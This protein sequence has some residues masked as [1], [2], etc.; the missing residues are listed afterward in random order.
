MKNINKKLL[1]VYIISSICYFA[2]GFESLP[3]LSLFF[4]LKEHLHFSPEK[5]M[6]L[7]S[8]ITIPWI[9]KPV[10]GFFIDNWLSHKKWIIL[11]SLL[12]ICTCLFFG[13]SPILTIPLIILLGISGN[14]GTAFRDIS[15]DA[16]M[17][18]QGKET[19]DCGN[20]QALQWTSITIASIIVGLVG[21]WIADHSTY[22][23]AFLCLAP[24]YL[25]IILIVSQYKE[26][27]PQIF[28]N[29][30]V[31]FHKPFFTKL[32]SYKEVFTNKRFLWAC[33][34]IFLYNYSP[35]FG[36][37]LMFIERDKFLWTGT[38]MGFLG[39]ITSAVSIIGSII[40]FK[41]GKKINIKKWLI[42]SVIFGSLTTL[43]YLYFT[44]ISAVIYG[45]LYSTIGMFI[46][47][48]IM[49]FMAEQTI[50]GKEAVS[51]AAL[52]SVNNLASTCSTV[53]GA[54]LYPRIGLQPL[55]IVSSLTS[56][57]CL[58]FINKL[59]VK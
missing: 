48:I 47:L 7:S 15:A 29:S 49:G 18:V 10:W 33:L 17:C 3:G 53:S 23:L 21:G 44:P 22:K 28:Y 24:I 46:F 6:F 4:Y 31:D 38:F 16:L 40:Y 9:I 11:S 37:P 59:E 56:F 34:F 42:G 43:S 57:I 39:A 8:L 51:F 58:L 32:L 12:S 20:I 45:L 36:T 13:L 41:I 1:W 26:A 35:G 52:C 55:I 54:W 27:E 14:I 25:I 5:I 19:N 30:S 2:Q 50:T